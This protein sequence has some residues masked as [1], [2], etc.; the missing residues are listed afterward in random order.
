MRIPIGEH[1]AI[2]MAYARRRYYKCVPC[3]YSG[4][5]IVEGLGR[6]SSNNPLFLDRRGAER[7][8]GEQ[9]AQR[10]Q[11][12]VDLLITLASCPKCGAHDEDAYK[13]YNRAVWL[14]ALKVGAWTALL[15][16]GVALFTRLSVGPSELTLPL[17]G[18][19]LFG[20]VSGLLIGTT[21]RETVA[22]VNR[23]VTFID[24]E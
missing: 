8:A 14:G 23:R 15:L 12:S 20:P 1:V 11:A 3:G 18:L 21:G 22:K 19:I 9:A 4:F 13:D 2:E 24:D 7:R 16:L 10:A 6:A 17:F 5:A